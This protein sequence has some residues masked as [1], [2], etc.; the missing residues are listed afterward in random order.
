MNR[1]FFILFVLILI[2]LNPKQLSS[3]NQERKYF[4]NNITFNITRLIL[5]EARFGY[6]RKLSENHVVRANLGI[7]FP[8]SAESFSYKAIAGIWQVASYYPVSKGTYLGLGYN[9]I[10]S[11]R[12]KIYISGEVYY[13]YS[14]YNKK[15][16]EHCAGGS[17][18]SYVSLQSMDLRKTGIK[19][20]FG[21][22]VLLVKGRKAGLLLDFFAGPGIQY[23]EEIITI[24]ERKSGTC[25]IDSDQEVQ[26][27]DPPQEDISKRWW[28]TFN[29]G[30]LI[31]VPF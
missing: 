3:Q 8:T 22:K 5:L 18:Y 31:G 7:Q 14:F 19:T 25:S 27:Y 4:K 30:I 26:E 12:S 13:N 10:I 16:Y 9:Y 17:S 24:Y 6:E 28:L 21:K 1:F 2:L 11:N 23:R 15:Y 29:A 20:L